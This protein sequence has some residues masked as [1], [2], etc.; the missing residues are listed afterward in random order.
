MHCETCVQLQGSAVL[1]PTRAPG[2]WR[3]SDVAACRM[4]S[5]ATRCS[6]AGPGGRRGALPT[7]ARPPMPGCPPAGRSSAEAEA[8]ERAVV[9]AAPAVAAARAAAG[10]A[11]VAGVEAVAVVAADTARPALGIGIGWRPEI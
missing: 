5:S 1:Q 6:A 3:F 4:P 2:R 7:G 9:V 8:G 10:V 11:A